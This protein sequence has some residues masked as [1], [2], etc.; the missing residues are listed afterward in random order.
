MKWATTERKTMKSFFGATAATKPSN[1]ASVQPTAASEVVSKN[2]ATSNVP[3]GNDKK[4]KKE[5]TT[6]Q[7]KKS[8]PTNITNFFGKKKDY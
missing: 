1:T 6:P 8:K 5:P 3:S 7:R 4:R 2:S